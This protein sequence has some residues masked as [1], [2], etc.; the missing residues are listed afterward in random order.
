MAAG[1]GVSVTGGHG[2]GPGVRPGPL[3]PRTRTRTGPRPGAQRRPGPH[4]E[5]HPG[6]GHR[7]GHR[8]AHSVP[9]D[10][11]LARHPRIL[12]R[13]VAGSGKTTL[14]QWLAVTAAESA[15][16]TVP[17]VLPLRTLTRHGER[18]P[19]AE[20]FL[21]AVGCPLTAPEGW[22]DRVLA[23]GRGIVLVDGIDE[24]PEPERERTRRWLRDLIG[25][26]DG[27]N[28]WLVTSRPSAVRDDW[29]ATDRFTELTL[30]AMS[31]SEVTTFVSRWHT[32][33][34]P[35]A[36]PY[37]QQ[38]IDTLQT[39]PDLARLATNPL[40]CGLICAL[41]RDR[42]GFLPEAARPCT[43][44]PFRCF[45]PAATANGTWEPRTGWNSARRRRS[46]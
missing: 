5:P 23:A 33:A 15:H 37:E 13:G 9:A 27:P 36:A 46:S 17:F 30:S 32:A 20:R 1:H 26:Y 43:T 31:R 38:L 4:P 10:H 25:A 22:A 11:A 12:L 34:G 3:G 18:L 45:S 8:P 21:S 41:H 28:R 44:R 24:V 35:D 42:R 19:P 14:V 40:M 7:P 29:L 2:P 39:T 6:S 16:G